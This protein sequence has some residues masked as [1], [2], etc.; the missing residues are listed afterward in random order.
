M[1]NIIL[2]QSF[3][4]IP[5]NSL[6]AK[7]IQ[8]V[9]IL[10]VLFREIDQCIFKLIY[11]LLGD[12]YFCKALDHLVESNTKKEAFCHHIILSVDPG[13]ENKILKAEI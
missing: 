7:L 4:L 12:S 6:A 1:D 11:F 2:L 13:A 3:P 8:S 9:L 5:L 10:A